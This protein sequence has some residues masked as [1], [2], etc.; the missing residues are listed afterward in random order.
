MIFISDFIFF[1]LILHPLA[2]TGF[3]WLT[4]SPARIRLPEFRGGREF[5]FALFADNRR[6]LCLAGSSVDFLRR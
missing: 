3:A 5:L 6:L 2:N 1:F 4:E